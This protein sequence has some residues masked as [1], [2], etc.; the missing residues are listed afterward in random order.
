MCPI[1]LVIMFYPAIARDGNT[2]ERLA[3]EEWTEENDSS[4]LGPSTRITAD[5]LIEN[6]A[7]K[8]QIRDFVASE[9]CSDEMKENYEDAKKASNL[10]KKLRSYIKMASYWKRQTFWTFK[11]NGKN[12]E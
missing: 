1:G 11:S 4:P 10:S 2:Y 6:R 7:L 5:V 9:D 8:N 12:G 3:I